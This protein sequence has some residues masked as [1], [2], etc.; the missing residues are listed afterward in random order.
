MSTQQP[1]YHV[2]LADPP[3]QYGGAGTRATR[4]HYPTMPTADI[5]ALQVQR[6]AHRNCSLLMWATAPC[7]PDAFEV[8][9]AWGFDYRT[10]AFCWAKTN[11]TTGGYFMGLGN[12]T[13]RNTEYCLLG[14]RGKWPRRA[15]ATRVAELIVA[16]RRE[17]S[18]KPEESYARILEL[19]DGPYL[20][21]FA[22]ELRPGWAAWGNQVA[23]FNDA[24][25]VSA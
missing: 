7:L 4:N 11:R 17:H 8:M 12:Y 6:V 1:T 24:G 21:L 9:R 25:R 10:V 2:I 15:D 3:W 18:R 19:F 22:R 23:Q 16:P 20:E 14:M 13:R 5:A